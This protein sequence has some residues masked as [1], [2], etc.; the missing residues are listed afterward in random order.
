MVM[1]VHSGYNSPAPVSLRWHAGPQRIEGNINKAF[2]SYSLLFSCHLSNR[3][4]D[5]QAEK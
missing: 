2:F 1:I 3:Q 5:R 4:T